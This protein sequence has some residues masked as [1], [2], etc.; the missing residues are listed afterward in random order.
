MNR[1]LLRHSFLSFLGLLS[2][3]LLC[4]C[5]DDTTADAGGAKGSVQVFVEAEDSVPDGLEPGDGPE[6][7][8]DGWKVTYDRYLV[9]IG[10]VRASRSDDPNARL[11]DASVYVLDLKNA[12]AGGYI[13]TTFSDATAVRWDQLGWDM[14][15]AK[16]GVKALAPTSDADLALMVQ[17]AYSVYFEGSIEK[18]DGQSCTPGVTPKSCAPA[19]KVAFKWGFSAGASFDDCANEEGVPGFAVPA[20]GTV[21]IKPTVHGDHW[22]FDNITSGAEVTTRLAQYIAD[23]DLDRNGETT[24]DELKRVRAADAF[25]PP[26]NV[27]G[28]LTPVQT[29]YDYVLNQSRT[30]GDYNGDGECPT[31]AILPL[32]GS[33][34]RR[35]SSPYSSGGLPRDSPLLASLAPAVGTSTLA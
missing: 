30:L 27:S 14:P 24:L 3:S 29:A 13:L 8:R 26:Y 15:N 23:S 5:S 6:N 32:R 22:F 17:N 11:N 10:N 25:P 2:T 21:Q 20:G 31:R 7:I 4:S 9:T 34:S 1:V 18:A 16:T 35:E 28:T 12:P 19:T 33:G